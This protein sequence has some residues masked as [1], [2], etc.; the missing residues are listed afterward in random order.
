MYILIN[1]RT[2]VLSSVVGEEK[3]V[4]VGGGELDSTKLKLCKEKSKT[5]KGLCFSNS[6]CTQACIT[7]KFIKGECHGFFRKCFCYKFC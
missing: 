3:L 7:E 4:V 5:K 2:E 1:A 6:K